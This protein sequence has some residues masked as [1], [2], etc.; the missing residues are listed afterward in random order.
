MP[1]KYKEYAIS[2]Y[3]KFQITAPFF[4]LLNFQISDFLSFLVFQVLIKKRTGVF[5]VCLSSITYISDHQDSGFLFPTYR[6]QETWND[7]VHTIQK[8]FFPLCNNINMWQ[9]TNANFWWSINSIFVK[10]QVRSSLKHQG[11]WC[12]FENYSVQYVCVPLF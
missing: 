5:K 3:S 10:T 9:E 6:N 8:G 4:K 7:R 2:T 11:T 12:P 1:L